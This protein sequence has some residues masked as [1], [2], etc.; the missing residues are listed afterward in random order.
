M[1]LLSP[2]ALAFAAAIPVL[3]V[4]YFM[5]LRRREVKVSAVFL[6]EEAAREARVDSFFQKLKL[7]LLLLLQVLALVLL[8]AALARPSVLSPGRS[9]RQLVIVLDTSASMQA[10]GRFDQA[11]RRA[12]ELVEEAPRGA[13]VMVV[14]AG[15]SAR[16]ELPFTADREKAL[17]T[18][19]RLTPGDVEGDLSAVRSL[20]LSVTGSRPQAEV[21]LLGDSL[22]EGPLHPQLRFLGFGETA[23][24][25][26]VTAFTA[27][28]PEEGKVEVFAAIESFSGQVEDV[29]VLLRRGPSTVYHRDMALPAGGRRTLVLSLPEEGSRELELALATGDALRV[30]D[31]AFAVIPRPAAL[32]IARLGGENRFLDR[33]LLSVP[34][35][36]LVRLEKPASGYPLTAWGTP[37]ERLAVQGGVQLVH[38]VPRDWQSGARKGPFRL[39]PRS[40]RMTAHLP[41]DRIAVAGV[42]TFSLPSGARMEV[43]AEA[44]GEPAL[45]LVRH[46]SSVALVLAFD[47]YASDLPLSP[48]FPILVARFV[49]QEVR[50]GHQAVPEQVAGGTGI[51]VRTAAAVRVSTPSGGRFPVTPREGLALFGETF[52]AG[53]YHVTV[54]EEVLPVAVNLFSPRESHLTEAPDDRQ[55]ETVAPGMLA[56]AVREYW[57]ELV[58]AALLVLLAE[59][60]LYHRPD[61]RWRP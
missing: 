11:R 26:G 53:F 17:R 18:L 5:K 43:L 54:G 29:T 21:V 57:W 40:H 48:A 19:A 8:V 46:E 55:G 13:E 22:P 7:N 58:L 31:R 24:N 14:S 25:L 52:E 59:W 27:T 33:A 47:L 61:W 50:P 60:L 42:D 35:A 32:R 49:E 4:L 16:I 3:V 44:G 38:G 9:A 45:A 23:A 41:L 6:W 51:P 39:E 20:V 12:L 30:D 10:P 2:A 15:R 28:A 56:S 1:S 37:P 36:R 34:G